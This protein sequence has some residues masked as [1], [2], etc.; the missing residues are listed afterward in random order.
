MNVADRIA[1]HSRIALQF[2]GGKD[3][4]SVA[5]LLRPYWDRL[6]FYHVDTGDL[7]PEVREI[8]RSVEGIV[9]RFVRIE[10]NSDEW[11][12]RFGLPSDLVP[13]TCTPFGRNLGMGK[14]GFRIVDR[15]NCCI[16]NIMEPMHFRMLA[17]G[18]SLVIRGTKRADTK[19]MAIESGPT[20]DGYELLL[21]IQEWSNA[22]V[23][24]Y[25][26]EIGAPICRVYENKVNAPE[27]ATCPAWW[28][29]GRASYLK[30]YHP[31]LFEGYKAKLRAVADEISPVLDTLRS[32][33]EMAK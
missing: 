17:D 3:S 12:M 11:M 25:L 30:K 10:T 22:D 23:F 15:F 28:D 26:K 33:M 16:A 4:L 7:L 9:P 27:C 1:A 18:I 2:S 8:V 19:R 6:T 5:Y 32:E 24:A 20:Q 29:E 14:G 21:P 13:T 31:D